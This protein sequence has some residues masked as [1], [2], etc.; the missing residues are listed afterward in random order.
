MGNSLTIRVSRST[1][2]LLRDLAAE[3]NTTMAGL[4][5]EAVRELQRKRFWDEFD[6]SITALEADPRG[7]EALQQEYALWEATLGDGL[8]DATHG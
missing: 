6:A 8:E 7:W 3:S 1:H 2:D 5:D 4:V